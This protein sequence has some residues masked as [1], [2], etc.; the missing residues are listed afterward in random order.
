[1]NGLTVVIPIWGD[2]ARYLPDCLAAVRK[3]DTAARV[4]VV[5]NAGET[6]LG[7]LGDDVTVIRTPT[8]LSVGAARNAG[9]RRVQ[10]EYVCFADVD[11]Q[12]LPGTWQFLLDRLEHD[13]K[14]VACAAQLWW[15]KEQTEEKR[16]APSPRPHVYR[17]LSGRRHAFALYMLLRMALPTTTVTIFRT[18]IAQDAGGY[19]DSNHAEDWVFAATV[20]LRGPVEQH[21]RP[22][23]LVRLHEGSLFNRAIMRGELD[24]GMAAVRARVGADRATPWWMHILM[25]AI[26]RFHARKADALMQE[27]TQANPM[28][29]DRR[30]REAA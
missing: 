16:P 28:D 11:D 15:W 18:R 17:H 6:P 21:R 13:G 12:V 30:S 4:I 3:Q 24:A 10:T 20:A 7:P 9:L 1:M 23:A 14:L 25:P 2:Y 26:A 19:G 27:T 22:G 29:A 5:D 8:R